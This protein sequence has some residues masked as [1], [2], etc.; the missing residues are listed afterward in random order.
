MCRPPQEPN[1]LILHDAPH[2]RIHKQFINQGVARTDPEAYRRQ[3]GSNLNV[4]STNSQHAHLVDEATRAVPPP[5][6]PSP[7]ATFNY[8]RYLQDDYVS[9]R[10]TYQRP[11]SPYLPRTWERAR[12]KSFVPRFSSNHYDYST[13]DSPY[14]YC[15]Q[16]SHRYEHGSYHSSDD[17]YSRSRKYPIVADATYSWNR[18]CNSLP[19]SF[20]TIRVRSDD[21]LERVLSNLT[22]GRVRSTHYPH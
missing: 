11:L 6:P 16:S 15:T 14:R 10:D 5:L 3:Y 9:C 13:H 2:A 22:N 17:Y 18:Y 1:L 4:W 20:H 12:V 21:E 7:S 8:Q 19:S